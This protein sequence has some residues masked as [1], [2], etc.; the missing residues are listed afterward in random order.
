MDKPTLSERCDQRVE[1]GLLGGL[2][3]E[4]GGVPLLVSSGAQR[5]IAFLAIAARPVSRAYVAG[6]L[7]P[8][9]TERRAAAS[10]RSALWRLGRLPV[11]VV[12]ARQGR[13]G[14]DVCVEVDLNDAMA[15][16]N[17]WMS[18]AVLPSDVDAGPAAL[19]GELLP[20]WYDDWVTAERERFR[21]LR[22]HGLEAMSLLMVREGRTGD[23]LLAALAAVVA[24]P[25]RESAHRALI[26]VHLAEGNVAEALRQARRYE[27]LLADELGVAPSSR[28]AALIT[29]LVP[30]HT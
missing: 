23:A 2:R 13:I 29:P 27:R 11:P 4:L 7:W 5:L 8:D 17:R 12:V 20:D 10:L 1:L 21:Q 14:L 30:A 18:G 26:N 15:A 24:D 19:E 28:L 6:S 3:L 25:L 22:L 16:A 9:V